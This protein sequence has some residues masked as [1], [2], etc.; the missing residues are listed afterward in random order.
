M[1]L[2]AEVKK[3][4]AL[5]ARKNPLFREKFGQVPKKEPQE[6]LLPSTSNLT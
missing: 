2:A 5:V 3:L 1:F 4:R 6:F